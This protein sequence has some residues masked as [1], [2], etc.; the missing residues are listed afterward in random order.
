MGPDDRQRFST[1]IIN[2]LIN[3]L[4]T[5]VEGSDREKP[6]GFR[7][8]AVDLGV[9]QSLLN[10]GLRYFSMEDVRER[11]EIDVLR[12]LSGAIHAWVQR[13]KLMHFDLRDLGI[14]V[15]LETQDDHGYYNYEFDIFPGRKDAAAS[16]TA[17]V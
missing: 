13:P 7:A 5:P 11:W 15:L 4:A 16:K 3:Q 9:L 12:W 6:Y 17:P 8:S 1:H 10:D 2:N 14:H